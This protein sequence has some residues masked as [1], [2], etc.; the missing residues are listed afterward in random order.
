MLKNKQI[1]L[2]IDH[3]VLDTQKKLISYKIKKY[4]KII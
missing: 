4:R 3:R 2:K 1:L